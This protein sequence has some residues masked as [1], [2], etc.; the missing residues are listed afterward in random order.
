[1]NQPVR[2]NQPNCSAKLY[3]KGMCRLHAIQLTTCS[4]P[5]CPRRTAEDVCRY[6]AV[7]FNIC[8]RIGCG[9]RCRG[10]YCAI[11]SPDFMR[12]RREYART[13]RAAKADRIIAAVENTADP[14]PD[15]PLAALDDPA[16]DNVEVPDE[17][18]A[19]L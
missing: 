1:M 19:G 12:K 3:N 16:N 17:L 7:V 8:G 11:H 14:M 18:L 10:N 2:C 15:D 9:K 13:Y 5:D 4:H 6:H